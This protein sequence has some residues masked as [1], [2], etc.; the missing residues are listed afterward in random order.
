MLQSDRQGSIFMEHISG[1]RFSIYVT[2]LLSSI[3][4]HG[5]VFVFLSQRFHVV[6]WKAWPFP[7]SPKGDGLLYSMS[8]HEER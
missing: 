3:P 8:Q 4:W 6:T 1:C 7:V 2:L 5:I